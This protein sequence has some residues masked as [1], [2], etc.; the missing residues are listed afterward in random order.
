M[1]IGTRLKYARE[2]ARL[3]IKQVAERTGIGQSSISEYETEKRTPRVSQLQ[4]LAHLYR[5]S[6][7][8]FLE[9][10][11]IPAETVLWRQKPDDEAA[12]DIQ[13]DF[14]RLCRQYHN[15]EVWCNEHKPCDL[16]FVDGQSDRFG[17]PDA[18]KL[19]KRVRDDLRLGERPGQSLLCVLEEV[20]GV[21]IFHVDLPAD[22]AAACSYDSS[23]GAAILLNRK[24]TRWRRNFDLAHEL[25]HILTWKVFRGDSS[26][27]AVPSDFEE[28]L[29]TCFAGNLLMPTDTVRIALN[30]VID[31]NTIHFSDLFG[32]ARQF[33]VSVEAICWRM[34]FLK[35]FENDQQARDVISRYKAIMDLWEKD[36]K[37]DNP[38]E[39]PTRFQALAFRALREGHISQGR[40]AEYMGI[41]RREAIRYVEQEAV[42]DEEVSVTSA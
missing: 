29:A 18:E 30:E 39:R 27:A 23:F 24:H 28:K 26:G 22:G 6:M 40:F 15:L 32:V 37:N 31:E 33:D 16:P 20:C 12:A 34:L 10:G 2:S 41:S 25:F 3:T 19:A 13:A 5:R 11:E 7:S 17:Y 38:P 9:E 14:L 1:P 4:S 36:R 35:F 21:K 8:F 42:D